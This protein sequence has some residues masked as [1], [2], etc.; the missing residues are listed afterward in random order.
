[1]QPVLFNPFW[2]ISAS[3]F[4]EEWLWKKCNNACHQ[5]LEQLRSHSHLSAASR[6][7][8]ILQEKRRDYEEAHRQAEGV[9]HLL[10]FG[11]RGLK[12]NR[13]ACLMWSFAAL[14]AQQ[15]KQAID[16]DVGGQLF[17]PHYILSKI[18]AFCIFLFLE[19]SG[20]GQCETE[21]WHLNNFFLVWLPKFCFCFPPI[22]RF[23]P[24]TLP[25]QIPSSIDFK[26]LR[27]SRQDT[28]TRLPLAPPR[29]CK[30][31]LDTVAFLYGG[32]VE[33]Q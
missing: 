8:D 19:P 14:N 28:P 32:C 2:V 26:I 6:E 15:E 29:L 13:A 11:T 21:P 10:S 16:F 22:Q 1:M 12:W 30:R 25:F 23:I 3:E 4:N 33:G 7:L 9:N 20:A 27:C 31:K 5:Y 18:G 24:K 17:H